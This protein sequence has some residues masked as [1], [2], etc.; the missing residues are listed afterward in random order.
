MKPWGLALA[1]ALLLLAGRAAAG[2]TLARVQARGE[3][4]CGVHNGGSPLSRQTAEGPWRG[5]NVAFC[6]ALAAAVLKDADAVRFVPVLPEN[7]LDR[8]AAGDLDVLMSGIGGTAARESARPVT[9]VT[10]WL[11]FGQKVLARRDLGAERLAGVDAATACLVKADT[12]QRNLRRAARTH[13]IDLRVETVAS[14]R[15]AV[16]GLASGRCDLLATDTLALHIIKA[17][18][19]GRPDDYVIFPDPISRGGNSIA[20]RADSWRW[21]K[22]VRWLR[23]GLVLAE[24]YGITRANVA[25]RAADG[26]SRTRRLLGAEGAVW[27]D[28]APDARWLRRAIAAVGNYGGI[29]ARYF[30]PDGAVPVPRGPNRLVRDGGA[31]RA[32]ALP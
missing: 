1:A 31:I 12:A 13:G 16:E 25:D 9:F 7:R 11:L 19:L 20:V 29:Y 14:Y 8:L 17:R 24:R 32:P 21:F 4:V 5:F 22:L 30:G 3:L 28:L 15:M 18:F 23:N 10:P 27:G 6:R 26:N 2:D